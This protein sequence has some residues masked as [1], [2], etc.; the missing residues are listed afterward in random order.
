MAP[1]LCRRGF[2]APAQRRPGCLTLSA[3][4]TR[5]LPSRLGNNSGPEGAC[6]ALPYAA[7]NPSLARDRLIQ[8]ARGTYDSISTTPTFSFRGPPGDQPASLRRRQHQPSPATRRCLTN[9]GRRRQRA[10]RNGRPTAGESARGAGHQRVR[11]PGRRGQRRAGPLRGRAAS[12]RR[13]P[14]P[15]PTAGLGRPGAGSRSGG[16]DDHGKR[17]RPRGL[18]VTFTATASTTGGGGGILITTNPPVSALSGEVFDPT[19]QPVVQVTGDGGAPVVGVEVTAS[20]ASGSGTLEGNTGV[21]TDAAGV[22]RFG[23]LG[24]SGS[25][26]TRSSSRRVTTP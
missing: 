17:G 25:G 23:D 24:I 11:S 21:T 2:V 16:A 10:N 15:A 6:V 5:P 19:V 9:R 20:L 8:P 12:R 7:T 1:G 26:L 13:R 4:R 22:A 18:P 3:V 14:R